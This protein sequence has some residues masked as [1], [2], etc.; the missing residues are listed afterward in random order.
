MSKRRNKQKRVS[1]IATV[2]DKRGR[3]LS[4]GKNSYTKTHPRMREL[5]IIVNKPKHDLLHAEIAALIKIKHGVP[6]KIK[7]ERYDK[8]GNPRMARP[9]DICMEGIRLAGIKFI[10][11]TIE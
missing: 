2:Y 4:I 6:Y 1:V 11:H 10:E 8:N 5:S 3:I 7:V 9:C